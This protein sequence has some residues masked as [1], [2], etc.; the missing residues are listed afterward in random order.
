MHKKDYTTASIVSALLASSSLGFVGI[1]VK[2]LTTHPLA[3]VSVR[4]FLAAAVLFAVT[5]IRNTGL[6]SKQE[7]GRSML[8]GIFL[9]GHWS[10]FFIALRMTPV[11]VATTALFTFPV[12]MAIVE[13]LVYRQ[14]IYG[15][16]ILSA[17]L[18]VIGVWLIIPNNESTAHLAGGVAVALLS[19]TLFVTRNLI[20]KKDVQKSDGI[21]LMGW[22]TLTAA[23]ILFPF[24]LIEGVSIS[25][26]TDLVLI[27]MLGIV[28]TAVSHTVRVVN[29]RYLPITVIDIISTSQVAIAAVAAWIILGERL[30]IINIVGMILI[31]GTV[32]GESFYFYFRGQKRA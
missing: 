9:A 30:G 3:L 26:G 19:A 2:V 28:L 8:A 27:L 5:G 1:I 14:K 11:A 20:C 18:T 29:M 13:P 17:L 24:V 22:Q 6:Q 21:A 16:Q 15:V 25:S 4:C 31:L 12:M 32:A 7:I 10:T 23:V